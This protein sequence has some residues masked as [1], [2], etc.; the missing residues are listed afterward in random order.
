MGEQ[1][2]STPEALYRYSPGPLVFVYFPGLFPFSLTD[3]DK[4]IEIR[5]EVSRRMGVAQRND[6][7]TIQHSTGFQG[8]RG[9]ETVLQE[10]F[11]W[12]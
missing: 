8:L 3:L 5:S 1:I 10:R 7:A 11:D 12:R 6:F 9:C 2:S 4:S